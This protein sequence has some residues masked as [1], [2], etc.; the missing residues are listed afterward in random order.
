MQL[1]IVSQKN[2]GGVP[3][4]IAHEV[5]DMKGIIRRHELTDTE[6][7]RVRPYFP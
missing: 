4:N 3:S 7:E 6:W 1:V 5:N 2:I